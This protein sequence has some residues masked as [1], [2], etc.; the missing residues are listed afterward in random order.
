MNLS[1]EIIKCKMAIAVQS[2]HMI[3]IRLTRFGL[4]KII[5]VT[6]STLL[7]ELASYLSK[8][9]CKKGT[10]DTAEAFPT[11]AALRPKL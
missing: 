4:Y 3:T 9:S 11:P 5:H 2:K 10:A 6:S 1:R 8:D 7:A